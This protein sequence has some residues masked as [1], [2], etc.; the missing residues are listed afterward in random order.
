VCDVD[1][2][3]GSCCVDRGLLAV[4][5]MKAGA[6]C[7]VCLRGST[8]QLIALVVVIASSVSLKSSSLGG[9][10]P[11]AL[12]PR[13]SL[14]DDRA[15]AFEAPALECGAHSSD[16]GRV[17]IRRAPCRVRY[18]AGSRSG[19]SISPQKTRPV[20]LREEREQQTERGA[21]TRER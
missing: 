1:V 20:G 13:A 6:D 18:G 17:C 12:L 3:P 14:A 4:A 16:S 5:D 9:R 10:S 19:V 2:V 7:A 15:H 21:S 11:L 8:R